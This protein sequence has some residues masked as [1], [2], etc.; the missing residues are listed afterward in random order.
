MKINQEPNGLY[1]R[2]RVKVTG[3]STGTHILQSSVHG[4]PGVNA[5]KKGSES[6]YGFGNEDE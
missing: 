4:T 1:V 3:I 5:Y 2:P 6:S